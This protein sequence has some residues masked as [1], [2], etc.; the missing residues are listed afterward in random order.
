MHVKLT[1]FKF[2]LPIAYLVSI[3][4]EV[5]GKIRKDPSILNRQKF[6]ELKQDGWVADTQKS[7]Q[8]LDF[9]P[10]YSLREALQETI[11]WYKVN[12]WL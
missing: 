7:K 8:K 3:G 11:D 9:T 5:L 4:A 10:Q 12:N 2:P 1:N 6:E